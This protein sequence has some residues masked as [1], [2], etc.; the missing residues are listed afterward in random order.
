MSVFRTFKVV[1]VFF[2]SGQN[3]VQ[4]FFLHQKT[5][6]IG[7]LA[8]FFILFSAVLLFSMDFFGGK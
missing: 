6:P 8:R 1:H 3:L 4:E 7:S 2:H 5:G